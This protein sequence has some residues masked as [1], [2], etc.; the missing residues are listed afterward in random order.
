M[1]EINEQLEDADV[2]TFKAVIGPIQSNRVGAARA[3][4]QVLSLSTKGR[5][6]VGQ[7]TGY[8]EITI[9]RGDTE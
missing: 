6:E 9:R 4:F 2:T 3:F 5:I 7:S 1:E 8:G